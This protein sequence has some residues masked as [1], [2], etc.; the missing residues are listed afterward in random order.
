VD[1]PAIRPYIGA[2]YRMTCRRLIALAVAYAVALNMVLPLLPAFA[3]AAQ[4]SETT[5]ATTA[6]TI[7]GPICGTGYSGERS[8][9]DLPNGHEPDCPFGL[10]C[11]ALNCAATGFLVVGAR[12]VLVLAPA[13]ASVF[14]VVCSDDAGFRPRDSGAPFARAPPLA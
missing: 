7:P 9:G 14:Q 13:S 3:P 4:A 12:G 11:S 5:G 6:K 1:A 2:M 10:A 8:G